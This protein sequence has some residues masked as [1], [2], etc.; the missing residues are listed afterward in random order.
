M[1]PNICYLKKGTLKGKKQSLEELPTLT[2]CPCMDKKGEKQ[3]NSAVMAIV[4]TEPL[5]KCC[6]PDKNFQ[7]Q[8]QKQPEAA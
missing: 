1:L 7:S 5:P 6:N 4:Q 2:T 3:G 8:L